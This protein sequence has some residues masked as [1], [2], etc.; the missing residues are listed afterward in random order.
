MRSDEPLPA[1]RRGIEIW[2]SSKDRSITDPAGDASLGW[3]KD[4]AAVPWDRYY[5]GTAA[6]EIREVLGTFEPDVVVMEHYLYR[7]VDVVRQGAALVVDCHQVETPYNRELAEIA[8][9][10]ARLIRSQLADRV[11]A[12][13][14]ETFA[15][16]TRC[17]PAAARR[18]SGS[19]GWHRTRGRS[20]GPQ[21]GGRQRLSGP[22]VHREPQPPALGHV[23]LPPNETAGLMLAEEIVPA[24]R[25]SRFP[26]VHLTLVG[27]SPTSSLLQ[28]SDGN[29]RVTVTGLVEDVRPH[30]AAAGAMPLPIFSGGGTR[31]KVLEAFAARVPLVSTAGCRGHRRN[32]RA[33]LPP[34]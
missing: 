19:P 20:S 33:A 18:R 26:D 29:D 7:Y 3:L 9:S 34:R 28:A 23:G 15:R 17:G 16:P 11:R 1:P 24:P 27:R 8:E 31:L 25:D 6:D 13:E 32:R 10:P 22:G 21:H 12:V 5:S 30:L 4:P 14:A 2:R